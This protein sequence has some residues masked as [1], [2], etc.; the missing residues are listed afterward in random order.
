[1]VIKYKAKYIRDGVVVIDDTELIELGSEEQKEAPKTGLPPAQN[2]VKPNDPA[3]D[4][5]DDESDDEPKEP[6][7]RGDWRIKQ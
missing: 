1:M 7:T 2:T 4:D 5:S 3:A 6:G